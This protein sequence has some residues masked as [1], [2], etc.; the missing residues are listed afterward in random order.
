MLTSKKFIDY[1]AFK[2]VMLNEIVTEER[3][4]RKEGRKE[5]TKEGRK[6]GRKEGRKER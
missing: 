5:E 6:K 4:R 1:I 3:R 2:F